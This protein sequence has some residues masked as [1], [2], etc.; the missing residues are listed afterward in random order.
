MVSVGF[1]EEALD[2]C[3][4]FDDGSE[5][6]AFEL[7]QLGEIAF[8]GVEPGCGGGGCTELTLIAWTLAMAAAVQCVVSPGG[9]AWVAVN[10]TIRARQTCSRDCR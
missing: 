5:H 3:L 10:N 6:A 1:G 7:L 9:S 8:D 4:K 2:G